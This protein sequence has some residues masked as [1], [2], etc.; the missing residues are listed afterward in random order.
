[1]F[2]L[3]RLVWPYSVTHPLSLILS[4]E[5]G[6]CCCVTSQLLGGGR[7]RLCSH[8][9]LLCPLCWLANNHR[10]PGEVLDQSR[11]TAGAGEGFWCLRRKVLTH[12]QC[13]CS[14]LTGDGCMWGG[15]HFT[16]EC[17]RLQCPWP[18]LVSQPL[19]HCEVPHGQATAPERGQG[20]WEGPGAL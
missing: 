10:F 11:T 5:F 9:P 17:G 14:P 18:C 7:G 15:S 4:A 16:G 12:F 20:R 2:R 8:F 6:W 1:M 19:L 3:Y 13:G